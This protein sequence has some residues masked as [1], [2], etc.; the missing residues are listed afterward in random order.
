M[1]EK[2]RFEKPHAY[3]EVIKRP[4]YVVAGEPEKGVRSAPPP[5]SIVEGCKYDFSVI[6]AIW[7]M[8]FAFHMPTYRQ[9]DWFGQCGWFPSRSTVN[10]LINY[11][12]A[13]IGPLHQQMWHLLLRQPI[14]LGDDT[15]LRVL[16]RG[17]STR[18][19]WP[20]SA[21]EVVSARQRRDGEAAGSA[22]SYAWL[23][24]GLD[25]FAPYNVFHWSLR[26]QNA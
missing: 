15:H 11:A 6:A 18:N 10:D 19:N 17:A 16:L 13:T 22:Q 9:Q 3:I 20:V 12:V 14:L 8:K 2:L 25:G 4:Q 24:T 1:T 26:H 7:A 23:Y 5:L 21:S